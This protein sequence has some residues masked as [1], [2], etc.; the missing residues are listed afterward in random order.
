MEQHE[1]FTGSVTKLLN[2]LHTGDELVV[3]QIFDYYFRRLANRAKYLLRSMGGIRISDEEDLASLVMT[4]FLKDAVAG[5]FDELRSRHDVWRML[6]A[7]IKYRG[8]N[9]V[10]NERNAKKGEVG[11]SVFRDV[12]GNCDIQGI[13]HQSDRG[14]DEIHALHRELMEELRDDLEREIVRLL[15]EGDSVKEISKKLN[16]APVTIYGRL[17]TIKKRWLASLRK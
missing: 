16:K 10:L 14:A 1:S 15:L 4:A 2:E 6:S 12:D 11:E 17:K 8:I 7:R 5:K 13:Q 9:I 3:Q